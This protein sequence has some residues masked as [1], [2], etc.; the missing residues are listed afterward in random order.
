MKAKNRKHLWWL[1][2]LLMVAMPGAAM[3]AVAVS[4]ECAWTTAD[5]VCE[6][7][8]DSGGDALISGGVKLN[9]NTAKLASPVAAKNEAQ[10]KFNSG[11]TIYPYMD[12]DVAVAGQ[13][14]FIVGV[15]DT[16]NPTAGINGNR[17]KIGNVSFTRAGD[18]TNPASGID[19]T[20]QA[21]FFGINAGLGK[22]GDYMNF[23]TAGGTPLDGSATFS[24][25]VAKRGDA[26]A[27]G[28][29]NVSDYVAVRNLLTSPS[30]PVYADCN[31]DTFVNVSDYICIRNNLE[32]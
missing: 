7:Y 27:D 24:A 2:A 1:V 19:G 25:K 13:V 6:I 17:I 21:V 26:N 12:P 15:L 10:W 18:L 14:V 29:I 23:V 9:Y 20:A 3:A 31:N 30:P 28:T 5:M 22:G 11:A 32:P 4:A 8:V 16:A